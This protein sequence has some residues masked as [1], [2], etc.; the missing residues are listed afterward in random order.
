MPRFH[1]DSEGLPVKY[2]VKPMD[3]PQMEGIPRSQR[4]KLHFSTRKRAA[5]WF[6]AQE[7][8]K[9][10]LR[11]EDE[12]WKTQFYAKLRKLVTEH[13]VPVEPDSNIPRFSLDA[14]DVWEDYSTYGWQYFAAISHLRECEL[15]V[16]EEVEIRELSYREFAG[17]D[18]D[19]DHSVGVNMYGG[20]S[21]ADSSIRC[22]CGEFS[23]LM[24]RWRGSLSAA[25]REIL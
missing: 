5:Q 18:C 9:M 2:T 20:D 4:D 17:T 16:P 6:A 7:S 23:G 8:A 1:L 12:V 14:Y 11:T 10:D 15:I 24:M 21:E 25:L 19:F 22:A 13:G 3:C